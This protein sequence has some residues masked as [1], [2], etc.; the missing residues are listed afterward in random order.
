MKSNEYYDDL[1]CRDCKTRGCLELRQCDPRWRC[2]WWFCQREE[3]EVGH[4]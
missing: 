3:M 2:A 4:E 1:I